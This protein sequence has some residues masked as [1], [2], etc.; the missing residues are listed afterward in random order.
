MSDNWDIPIGDH[1][2]A[3]AVLNKQMPTNES[4]QAPIEEPAQPLTGEPAQAATPE[5]KDVG[6]LDGI[7][8]KYD[9][10]PEKLAA[11]YKA[12]QQQQSKQQA[13]PPAAPIPGMATPEQQEGLMAAAARAVGGEQQFNAL[14]DWATSQ[15]NAGNQQ[16][17]QAVEA[18]QAGIQTGDAQRAQGALAQVQLGHMQRYGWQPKPT[19]GSVGIGTSSR[20]A[21]LTTQDEINAAY[22]DP[23]MNINGHQFDQRYYESVLR[24]IC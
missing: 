2:N 15:I 10:D 1:A 8:K 9:N 23:R 21:P 22:D 17:T 18:F 6:G 20:E 16:V 13:Q 14:S 24:R 7:L 3:A 12:L 5:S 11:A 4:A 19:L